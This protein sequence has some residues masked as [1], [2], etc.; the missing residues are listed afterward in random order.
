MTNEVAGKSGITRRNAEIKVG[1]RFFELVAVAIF[2]PD[3]DADLSSR[4]HRWQLDEQCS[5]TIHAIALVRA[6]VDMAA[7]LHK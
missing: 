1:S 6:P 4:K 7:L 5:Q 3:E 2:V